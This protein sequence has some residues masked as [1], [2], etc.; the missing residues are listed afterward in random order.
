MKYLQVTMPDNSI[1]KVEAIIIAEDRA[2]YLSENEGGS[3]NLILR[4]TLADSDLLIEWAK[5][6]MNWKDVKNNAIRVED[7]DVDYEDGWC[8]GDKVIIEE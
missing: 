1:W 4:E 6:E 5:N 3:Y 7:C 2:S 8:N